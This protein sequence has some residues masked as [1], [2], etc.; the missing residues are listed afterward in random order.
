MQQIGSP[1]RYLLTPTFPNSK[2]LRQGARERASVHT[3]FGAFHPQ[4][5]RT[6]VD[7][8]QGVADEVPLGDLV[9]RAVAKRVE[10]GAPA[11]C[12]KPI[13]T[14]I[15]LQQRPAD[16]QGVSDRMDAS[17]V[18]E[19]RYLDIALTVLALGDDHLLPLIDDL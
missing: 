5:V 6:E 15:A 13:A 7:G 12:A 9:L 11:L 17:Q 16:A 10:D 3:H 19:R 4:L 18:G 14:E 8:R 2:H 1:V